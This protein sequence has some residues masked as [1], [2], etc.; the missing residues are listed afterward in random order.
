M[1]KFFRHL[2]KTELIEK[3][4]SGQTSKARKYF[5]YAFGEIVLV[6]I[7]I[8][9][10]LQI[11]NWNELQKNK[12]QELVILTNILQDIKEDEIGLKNII[13]KRTY[14]VASADITASYYNSV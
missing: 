10:A 9:I 6:V 13:E 11:N 12:K 5:K 14:K 8:L 7:G 2:R 3:L 4:P 1:M